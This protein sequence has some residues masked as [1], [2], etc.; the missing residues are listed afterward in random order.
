MTAF[1]IGA[2][3]A[4]FYIDLGAIL[5]AVVLWIMA[6]SRSIGMGYTAC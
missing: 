2:V 3:A 1:H 6:G 4:L 5:T